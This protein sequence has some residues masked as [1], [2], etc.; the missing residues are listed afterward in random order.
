MTSFIL[1]RLAAMLVTLAVLSLVVFV[2]IQMPPGDYVTSYIARVSA[3]G[4]QVDE[5]SIAV[6]RAAYGLDQ[7]VL[8]QYWSWV[9]GMLIGNFGF[10]F[11]MKTPVS[12][13]FSQRIGISLI[14]EMLVIIVM[15][16]ISIPLGIYSAVRQYSLGDVLATI[17][18]FIGLAIPNFLFAL[19][20]MYLAY[21]LFG[22]TITGL[23]SP[24][25]ANERWSLARVLDFASYVWAPVLVIASGGS[26]HVIRILRANLLDELGKPYVLTARAKG[27]KESRLIWRYPVRVALNPL[28]STA[29]YI[30]P[31]VISSSFVVS[32]VLN[33]PTLSPV[34]LH[35]LLSQDMYL[36]G[37]LIMFMG[38][39]TLVGTLISDLL[40]AWADPRIRLGME[41]AR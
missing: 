26:A 30:L 12:E 8:L 39:L 33:L 9:S 31:T 28:I 19:I 11:D 20:L 40:L 5:T 32:V 4:E 7:P 13:I 37:A 29:G 21:T 14:L 3:Q 35:A 10:S 34:L 27:L 22:V 16:G 15:W 6:L 18:G 36:A 24:E 23:F 1:R 41:N 38:V 2:V 25:L 17:L